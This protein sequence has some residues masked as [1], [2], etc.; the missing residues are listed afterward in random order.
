MKNPSLKL[1]LFNHPRHKHAKP[2]FYAYKPIIHSANTNVTIIRKSYI[3]CID[4]VKKSN[5]QFTPLLRTFSLISLLLNLCNAY[6]QF[7]QR[8]FDKKATRKEKIIAGTY[9]LLLSAFSLS[10]YFIFPY[11]PLIALSFNLVVNS[12]SWFNDC[13][14]YIKQRQE[15][16]ELN[17]CLNTEEKQ[18]LVK[19]QQRI[20][21]ELTQ[22][23]KGLMQKKQEVTNHSLLTPLI[24]LLVENQ[25]KLNWLSNKNPLFIGPISLFELKKTSPKTSTPQQNLLKR[26]LLLSKVF[27]SLSSLNLALFIIGLITTQPPLI[28]SLALLVIACDLLDLSRILLNKTLNNYQTT[29]FKKQDLK[30]QAGFFSKATT[31]AEK[32]NKPNYPPKDNSSPLPKPHKTHLHWQV[33]KN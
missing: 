1:G 31:L 9:A 26:Q 19:E 10:A 12:L 33:I 6:L 4:V 20:F 8:L 24:I 18:K 29:L 30:L 2:N 28:F 23:I 14:N 27:L 5:P 15:L 13:Y 22:K 11:L 32:L 7:L 16:N 21:M 17:C 3:F 25:K